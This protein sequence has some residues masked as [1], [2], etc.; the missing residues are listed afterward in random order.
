MGC[1]QFQKSGP[2]GAYEVRTEGGAV[3]LGT[4]QKWERR[5]NLRRVYVS[6]GWRATTAKGRRL[7]DR[8]GSTARTRGE[9]AEA[10]AKAHEEE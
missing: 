3:F 9:A 8:D 5:Y 10:L 1:F 7:Y 6:R 4:V 2:I